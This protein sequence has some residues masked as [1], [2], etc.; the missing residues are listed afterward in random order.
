MIDDD[1]APV[2]AHPLQQRQSSPQ[3]DHAYSLNTS[4]WA[5]LAAAKSGD[6]C[7]LIVPYLSRHRMA[8]IVAWS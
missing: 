6:I 8:E 3:S 1:A 7:N 2:T 5:N 4:I